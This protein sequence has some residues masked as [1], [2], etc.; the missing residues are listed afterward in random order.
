M[1]QGAEFDAAACANQFEKG[2][3]TGGGSDPDCPQCKRFIETNDGCESK[4][5]GRSSADDQNHPQQRS[6]AF[7][8]CIAKRPEQEPDAAGDRR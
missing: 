4:A 6:G 3:G 5:E 7:M 8:T 1:A 2:S